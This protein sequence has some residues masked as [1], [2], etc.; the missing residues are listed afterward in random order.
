MRDLAILLVHVIRI[1]LKLVRPG[2]VRTAAREFVL[3]K[4]QLLIL[5]RSRQRTR[6]LRALD[7]PIGS[8]PVPGAASKSTG[9]QG[10][11]SSA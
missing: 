2:G 11:R 10:E 7:R 9:N 8:S 1:I 3:A 5:N 4:H 6:N